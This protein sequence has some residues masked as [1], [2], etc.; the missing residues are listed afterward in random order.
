MEIM[1][2]DAKWWA[3][4]GG[5]LLLG[6]W[7]WRRMGSGTE[8]VPPEDV[9]VG[10]DA[11]TASG[12]VQGTTPSLYGYYNPQTGQFIGASGT[13]QVITTNAQWAQQVL[14]SMTVSFVDTYDPA[15]MA[16]AIANYLAGRAL[17]D[18]EFNIVETAIQL[19]GRPPTAV[20]EP[21]KVN[22]TGG[23]TPTP[24]FARPTVAPSVR[25]VT[26]TATTLGVSW[27]PVPNAT[28]YYVYFIS[29][30]SGEYFSNVGNVTRWTKVGGMVKGKAYKVQVAAASPGGTGPR[31]NAL[32]VY[33]K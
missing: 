16:L 13:T 8:T 15:T 22:P 10:E 9:A 25:L 20:P 3:A 17:T 33:G 19:Y 30:T 28:T 5:V 1:G 6:V 11:A 21:H 29:P 24:T 32:T 4:G 31:S 26:N 2:V 7:Y 23:Q 12:D 14:T 18:T 27:N